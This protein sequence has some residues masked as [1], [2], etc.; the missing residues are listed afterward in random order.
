MGR[1]PAKSLSVWCWWQE[2]NSHIPVFQGM[3]LLPGHQWLSHLRASLQSKHGSSPYWA[4]LEFRGL[5]PG[6]PISHRSTL[7]P[8]VH[9]WMTSYC[10][11][12]GICTPPLL[13]VIFEQYFCTT[14]SREFYN[15]PHQSFI[16]LLLNY[17]KIL[18][19]IWYTYE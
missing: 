10:C 19:N 5:L 16:Y 11:S 13:F 18:N 9:S 17:P 12:Q 1:I 7:A 2:T 14:W 3:E 8:L 15:F 6:Y 4:A